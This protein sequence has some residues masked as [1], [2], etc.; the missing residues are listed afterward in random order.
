MK[1][2][3]IFPN[4]TPLEASDIIVLNIVNIVYSIE[5]DVEHLLMKS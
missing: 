3:S 5:I 2:N 1:K 4:K